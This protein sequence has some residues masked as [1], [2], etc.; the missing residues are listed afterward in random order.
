MREDRNFDNGQRLQTV[1]S[2]IGVLGMLSPLIINV[3]LEI[4]VRFLKFAVST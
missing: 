4:L 3:A 2:P 1:P